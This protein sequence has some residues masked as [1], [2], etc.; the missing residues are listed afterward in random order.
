MLVKLAVTSTF[1]AGMWKD[2]E[3][4][5]DLL[6]SDPGDR[7]PGKLVTA[8][9]VGGEVNFRICRVAVLVV[10]EMLPPTDAF[11]VRV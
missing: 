4:A 11:T 6:S 1:P 3:L 2:R 9:G 5:V 8:A 10:P 7:P